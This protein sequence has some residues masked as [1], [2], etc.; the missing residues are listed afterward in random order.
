MRGY[1]Y[2]D[3]LPIKCILDAGILLGGCVH[4]YGDELLGFVVNAS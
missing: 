1:D 4:G 3:D 2:H